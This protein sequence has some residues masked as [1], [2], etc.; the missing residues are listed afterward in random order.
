MYTI[1]SHC[2][3]LGLLFSLLYFPSFLSFCAV[4]TVFFFWLFLLFHIIKLEVKLIHRAH[5]G[6]NFFNFG[7]LM[8][9]TLKSVMSLSSSLSK[10]SSLAFS[11]L[12]IT[13]IGALWSVLS[14][15]NLWSLCGSVFIVYYDCWSL[16]IISHFL[17]PIYFWMHAGRCVWNCLRELFVI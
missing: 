17:V 14:Y 1:S 9:F 13:S 3:L 7:I 15:P 12:N 6:F 5:F 16:L 10:F 8:R 11:F 4:H 2:Y